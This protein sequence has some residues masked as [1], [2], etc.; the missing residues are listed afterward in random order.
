VRERRP[1]LIL[2]DLTMPVMDGLDATRAIRRLPGISTV[3]ILAMTAVAFAEDRARCLAT[4][5]NGQ[6]RQAG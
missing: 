4:G 5:M 6:H 1:A 2:M 3:P